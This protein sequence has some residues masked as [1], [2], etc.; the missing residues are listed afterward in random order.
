ML[1]TAFHIT[2]MAG[3]HSQVTPG[4]LRVVFAHV[5]RLMAHNISA[6]RLVEDNRLMQCYLDFILS[7]ADY[8]Q[9]SNEFMYWDCQ[10]LRYCCCSVTSALAGAPA[11]S[12]CVSAV[13]TVG[14]ACA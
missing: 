13:T 11:I 9:R 1:C 7:T 4:E 3:V 6:A 12:T 2:C 14:D 5:V 10:P 8:C